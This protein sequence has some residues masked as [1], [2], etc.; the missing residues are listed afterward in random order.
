MLIAMPASYAA[1]AEAPCV[2]LGIGCDAPPLPAPNFPDALVP[3]IAVPVVI[4]AAPEAPGVVISPADADM[5]PDEPIHHRHRRNHAHH[6][7]EPNR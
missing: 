7:V 1:P 6:L 2:Y 4:G 5:A 3:P